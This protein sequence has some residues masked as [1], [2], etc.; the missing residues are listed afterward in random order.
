MQS[1]SS[2]SDS[3]LLVRLPVL[4]GRERAAIVD[5]IEHLLE[6][7][8]RRLYLEEGCSS[9]YT[10]CIERLFYSEDEALKRVRAAR[11]AGRL[12]R[13]LEDLE[14]AALHLTGLF[15]LAPH[16]TEENGEALLS[17]AR[18]KSRREIEKLLARWFPKP[19]VEPRM[20]PVP[21]Q[22]TL[23][24]PR[25]T[26]GQGSGP[27]LMLTCP[28]P[29]AMRTRAQLEPLSASSYRVEFTASAELVAKIEQA[30]EL[31]SHALPSGELPA[32]FERAMDALIE[33]EVR[34]RRGIDAGRWRR[35]R[36]QKLGSRHVP[37]EVA[38][39]VWE[40]DGG[41]C[42]YVDALGRRCSE[43]RFVTFEHKFPHA[44]GGPATVENL[45]LLCASHNAHTARQMFGAAHI[46]RKR[47]ERVHTAEAPQSV[48]P[49]PAAE[50]APSEGEQRE[51]AIAKVSSALC[52][53]GFR[54]HQVRQVMAELRQRHVT[55]E[56]EPLLRAGL[57]LLVPG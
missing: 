45:C 24:D 56:P 19:D 5:V 54:K 15:L 10:F 27:S 28:G 29:G 11:L 46:N 21:V 51:Q 57:A 37:V 20:E 39:M 33:R 4:V 34:R 44:F 43:R 40:R 52:N 42:T 36:P 2:V 50:D 1:L 22:G 25:P 53:M 35:R 12:P 7:D 26:D 48:E 16:L 30:R 13:V 49:P 18:G 3:D 9:L 32:L 31:L 55:P 17:E 38:R 47:R 23:P 8:R 6:V 14:S 41:Q